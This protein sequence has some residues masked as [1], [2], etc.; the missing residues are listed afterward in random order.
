MYTSVTA[1]K[2][3]SFPESQTVVEGLGIRLYLQCVSELIRYACQ[4]TGLVTSSDSNL[5]SCTP[6]P[7]FAL[8]LSISLVNVSISLYLP[9]VLSL[10]IS[11]SISE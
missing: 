11:L 1:P 2:L 7:M 10:H 6:D 5:H 4:D 9:L 8:K 3:V